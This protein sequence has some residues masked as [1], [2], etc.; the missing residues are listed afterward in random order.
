MWEKAIVY[1]S[2]DNY[3]VQVE[4]TLFPSLKETVMVVGEG[5]VVLSV[6]ELA[7]DYNIRIGDT[8]EMARI[9]CPHIVIMN[10]HYEDYKYYYELIKNIYREYSD[11]VESYENG[12]IWIDLTSY[13]GVYGGHPID[14]ANVMRNRIYDELGI[15]VDL[16]VSFNRLFA[17]LALNNK[18]GIHAIVRRFYK[19]DAYPLTLLTTPYISESDLDVLHQNDIYTVG[20]IAYRSREMLVSILQEKGAMIW[21]LVHGEN[22]E[23]SFRY[24]ENVQVIGENVITCGDI[25]HFEEAMKLCESHI[26]TLARHLKDYQISG[27]KI[28]IRMRDHDFH[29]Y[30]LERQLVISTNECQT[31]YNVVDMLLRECCINH[32]SGQFDKHYQSLTIMIEDLTYDEIQNEYEHVSLFETHSIFN[33]FKQKLSLSKSLG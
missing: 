22:V 29:D 21:D 26:I 8:L 23:E 12:E 7:K 5:N 9:K 11:Q 16:G 14:I 25:S 2:I 15:R 17:K 28:V 19:R 24:E 6:N 33:T 27:K 32:W 20:A 18:N 1:S 3:Y 10:P 30:T 31:I 4:E 13:Q